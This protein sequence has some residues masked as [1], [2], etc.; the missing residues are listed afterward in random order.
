[1]ITVIKRTAENTT[2]KSALVGVWSRGTYKG[3]FPGVISLWDRG[4]ATCMGRASAGAV[5]HLLSVLSEVVAYLGWYLSSAWKKDSR[6]P[7]H[8]GLG[9]VGGGGGP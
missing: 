8:H 5:H 2:P 4:P 9:P 3:N 6:A 7:H 1:M